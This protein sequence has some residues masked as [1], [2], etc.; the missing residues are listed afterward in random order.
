[1]AQ[2][3]SAFTLLLHDRP[4]EHRL[5]AQVPSNSRLTWGQHNISPFPNVESKPNENA[6]Q[7][8]WKSVE[9]I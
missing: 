2:A 8:L 4:I 7:R 5:L 1:M 3:Q 9:V 6:F